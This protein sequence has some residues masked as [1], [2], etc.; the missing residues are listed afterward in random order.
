MTRGIVETDDVIGRQ[1]SGRHRLHGAAAALVALTLAMTAAAPAGAATGD[2]GISTVAAGLGQPRGIAEEASG[3]RLVVDILGYRLL[4]VSPSGSVTTVAGAGAG[5]DGGPALVASL[6]YPTDVIVIDQGPYEGILIADEYNQ[7]IRRI[8]PG[9]TISTVAGTGVEGYTGD[10]G[11]AAAATLRFPR[12]LSATGD[13]GFL[14]AD[15]RNHVI[16][17]VTPGGLIRTV[18]G[19]GVAGSQGDGVPATSASLNRPLGV[20]WIGQGRFAIAD[21]YNDCV[22][23]VDD[24]TIRTIAGRCG[25]PGSG[26]DGGLATSARLSRPRDV[27]ATTDGGFYIADSNNERVRRISADGIISTVAGTGAAGDPGEGPALDANLNQPSNLLLDG[28]DLLVADTNNGRIRRIDHPL[29][30]LT[31]LSPV[32]LPADAR[33]GTLTVTGTGF[34]PGAVVLWGGAPRPTTRIGSTRLSATLSASDLGRQRTVSVRVRTGAAG[35]DATTTRSFVVGPPSPQDGGSTGGPAAGSG[36]GRTGP[37]AAAGSGGGPATA[38]RGPVPRVRVS[39]Q[40]RVRPGRRFAVVVR[41]ISAPAGTRVVLRRQVGTR[42]RLVAARPLRA[43]T[44]I[45]VRSP[46]APGRMRLRVVVTT[47][48]GAVVTRVVLVHVSWA[49]RA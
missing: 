46:R 29:P 1:N 15:E 47:P 18:A 27:V 39:A 25:S 48:R 37:S 28:D 9:G 31:G 17:E 43:L 26:G 40:L 14:I 42:T 33:P 2:G 34:G 10:G 36:V 8:D 23:E 24:A 21:G 19:N 4:R 35:G 13:G 6:N 44:R 32:T 11:P 30:T 38:G 20:E 22:R 5:G 41:R 45:A 3:S 16:R 12:A 7:R 49:G